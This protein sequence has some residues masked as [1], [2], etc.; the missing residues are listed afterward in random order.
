MTETK[1]CFRI[2][3][4]IIFT[5]YSR[6]ALHIRIEIVLHVV[7]IT[8]LNWQSGIPAKGTPGSETGQTADEKRNSNFSRK[9]QGTN[10]TGISIKL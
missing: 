8:G 2:I 7:S 3:I 5:K 6:F 10:K 4:I 1:F 9:T